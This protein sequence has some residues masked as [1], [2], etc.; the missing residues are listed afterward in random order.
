MLRHE[1]FVPN[2]DPFGNETGQHIKDDPRLGRLVSIQQHPHAVFMIVSVLRWSDG[3]EQ[4]CT[5]HL[6]GDGPDSCYASATAFE[7]VD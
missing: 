4:F 7:F 1:P 3:F 6:R 5:T 2:F